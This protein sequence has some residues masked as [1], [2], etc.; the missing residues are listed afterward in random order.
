MPSPPSGWTS[1]GEDAICTH[2]PRKR[3]DAEW[4]GEATWKLRLPVLLTGQLEGFQLL[5]GLNFPDSVGMQQAGG[6]STGWKMMEHGPLKFARIKMQKMTDMNGQRINNWFGSS[7]QTPLDLWGLY[8]VEMTFF[9]LVSSF[10][11]S[12]TCYLCSPMTGR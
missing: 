10:D 12:K 6:N 5:S 3:G 4:W 11:S 9:F 7:R 1:A 2:P 8:S